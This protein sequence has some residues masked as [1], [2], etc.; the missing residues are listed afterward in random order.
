MGISLSRWE[1]KSGMS[2]K[3]GLWRIEPSLSNMQE[4]DKFWQV[5]RISGRLKVNPNSLPSLRQWTLADI[6]C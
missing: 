6:K 3:A 2:F 4:E 1:N 5:N